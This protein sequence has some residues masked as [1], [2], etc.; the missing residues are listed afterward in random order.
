VERLGIKQVILLTRFRVDEKAMPAFE[1]QVTDEDLAV[2]RANLF[3]YLRIVVPE[4]AQ[5]NYKTL[6]G[7]IG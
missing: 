2:C 1:L 3:R 7:T 5:R 6:L 4:E